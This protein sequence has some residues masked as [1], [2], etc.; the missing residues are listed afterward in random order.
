LFRR[1]EFEDAEGEIVGEAGF[2]GCGI[3]RDGVIAAFVFKSCLC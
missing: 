1:R 2:K 3:V